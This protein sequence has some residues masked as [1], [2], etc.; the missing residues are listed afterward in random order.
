[1]T[2]SKVTLLQQFDRLVDSLSLSRSADLMSFQNTQTWIKVK[3]CL[4]GLRIMKI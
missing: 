2:F 3:N 4:R 1:M